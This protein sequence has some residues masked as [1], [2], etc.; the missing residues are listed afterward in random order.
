MVLLAMTET[1]EVSMKEVHKFLSEIKNSNEFR[2][3]VLGAAQKIGYGATDDAVADSVNL[4]INLLISQ[5]LLELGNEQYIGLAHHKRKR[6][7]QG[8]RG[9]LCR[10]AERDRCRARYRETHKV[11]FKRYNRRA[12]I[13]D[14]AIIAFIAEKYDKVLKTTEAER[15][16][17]GLQH[18]H[19][20]R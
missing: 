3:L 4:K 16:Q 18:E 2:A 11:S 19:K 8:C 17:G 5:I 7:N 6:Y 14:D 9:P 15:K 20:S 13:L 10:K 12:S 1:G